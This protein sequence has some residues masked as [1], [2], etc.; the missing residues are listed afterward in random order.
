MSGLVE[1][2]IVDELRA[3]IAW[4]RQVVGELSKQLD[5]QS[6]ASF[7]LEKHLEYE[8]ITAFEQVVFQLGLHR[9]Q[10]TLDTLE[11][12]CAECVREQTGKDW[13]MDRAVLAELFRIHLDELYPA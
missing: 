5:H 13:F 2:K 10:V 7:I 1:G 8:E 3:E 4:L 12:Q 11:D 9:S 6:Y